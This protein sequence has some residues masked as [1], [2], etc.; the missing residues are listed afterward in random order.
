[1]LGGELTAEYQQGYCDGMRLLRA[2]LIAF[3]IQHEE[4]WEHINAETKKEQKELAELK[5]AE[6]KFAHDND[7]C[8]MYCHYCDED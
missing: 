4:L 6:A 7:E 5:E 2:A 8:G 1:M 3:D